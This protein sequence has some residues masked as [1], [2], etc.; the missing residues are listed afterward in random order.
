MTMWIPFKYNSIKILKTFFS[1]GQGIV[2][3][4]SDCQAI[5]HKVY[6]SLEENSET[7][8]IIRDCKRILALYPNYRVQFGRRQANLVAH[9]LARISSYDNS[10]CYYQVPQCIHNL[11]INE[12]A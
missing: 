2:I 5:V 4:E 3:F 9:N 12:M 11:I 6:S 7:D 8:F 1:F 10:V